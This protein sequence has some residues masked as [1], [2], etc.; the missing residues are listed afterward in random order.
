MKCYV[1]GENVRFNVPA[2]KRPAQTGKMTAS[3]L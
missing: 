2:V 1:W 3:A